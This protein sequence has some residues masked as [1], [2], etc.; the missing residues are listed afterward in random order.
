MKQI[1]IIL[2]AI[3]LI[4]GM[5]NYIMM[6]GNNLTSWAVGMVFFILA[7]IPVFIYFGLITIKTSIFG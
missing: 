7:M 3:I 4:V 1:I 6:C 2:V 5:T